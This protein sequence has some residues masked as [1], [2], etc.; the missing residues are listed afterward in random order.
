MNVKKLKMIMKQKNM[1]AYK[2]SK[3]S[4]VKESA[5]SRILNKK[6]PDPQISTVIKIA[7]AL[8]VS[9]DEIVNR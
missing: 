8:D 6:T 9:I 3:E 2:L 1:T 5:L 7:N 4:G